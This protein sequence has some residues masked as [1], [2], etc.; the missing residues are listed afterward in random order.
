M[1]TTTPAPGSITMYTTSWC[2]Y[3]RRLK[4]QLEGEGIAYQE[5]NI[6]EHPEAA[7]FVEEVNGGNQTVPTVLFPDGS[8]ATNP[9]LAEVRTR[10]G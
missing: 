7:S 3:C 5:V 1:T 10:L 4:K 9:S 6:E 2:G 8:S